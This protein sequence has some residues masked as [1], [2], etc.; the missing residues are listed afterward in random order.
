MDQIII[1]SIKRERDSEL[2]TTGIHIVEEMEANPY[3]PDPPAELAEVKKL[4]PEYQT[5][6]ANAKGRNTVM[7]SIKKDRKEELIAKLIKLGAYVTLT[8]KGD[9]T[10]LLSSGFP[11]SGE[12]S[13]QPMAVIQKLEVEIGSPG[14]ATTRVKRVAGAR[15]YLHQYATEQ[16]TSNTVW[17]SE[18]TS[19]AN[20][21]FKGLQSAVKYWFR[22]VALGKNG[23]AVNSPVMSRIIQ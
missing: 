5:A 6:V 11:I 7:V 10:M 14:E 22:V 15:A 16:P 19:N 23:Q 12:K 3:F 1:N 9:R 2:A 21:T 18:G 13:E 4:L 20:Y 17:I 8:C